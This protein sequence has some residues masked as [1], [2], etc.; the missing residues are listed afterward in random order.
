[1]KK[2]MVLIYITAIFCMMI[3]MFKTRDTLYEITNDFNNN[4]YLEVGLKEYNKE[5]V[6]LYYKQVVRY[7]IYFIYYVDI[8]NLE[9]VNV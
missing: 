7:L 3:T 6:V 4:I 1:M 9:T 2:I 8:E 5:N